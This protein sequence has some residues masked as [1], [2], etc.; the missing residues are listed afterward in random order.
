M[1]GSHSR[2]VG[3]HAKGYCSHCSCEG[4]RLKQLDQECQRAT[5]VAKSQRMKVG[6]ET[7]LDLLRDAPSPFTL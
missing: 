4:Y 2:D 3:V 6:V 5:W 1:P 7:M